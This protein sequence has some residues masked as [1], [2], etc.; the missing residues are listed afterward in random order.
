MLVFLCIGLL[1]YAKYRLDPMEDGNLSAGFF[2]D[3]RDVFPQYIKNHIP[4]GVRGLMITGLLAAALSS[5]NSAI[6]SMA[7]SFVADLYMPIRR[8]RGK[9]VGNDAEQIAS[10]RWIVVLMGVL[11]TAFAILTCVMQQSSGLNLVD[12]ATGV[13]SV[14]QQLQCKDGN[15][16][17]ETPKSGKNRTILPAPIVMDALRNQLERQQKEQEQAGKKWNN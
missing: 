5:F 10:S 6:N 16:F 9:A 7:S 11:L 15:Y 8:Q 2:T 13:I 3:A 1:L 14:K 4:V 12:F 17:L